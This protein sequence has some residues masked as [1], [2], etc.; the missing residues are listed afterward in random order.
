MKITTDLINRYLTNK[1]TAEEAEYLE[2]YIQYLGTSL[3]QLLPLEEWEETK[4]DLEYSGEEEIRAKILAAIVHKRKISFR[5]RMLV[6]LSGVAALLI[7]FLGIYLFLNRSEESF[8]ADRKDLATLTADSTE[9]S[10]L[11]YI[12]SG[13]ENMSLTASD[14]SVITLYPKSEIKYAENF[15]HLKERVLYLKGK[16]RFEVAKDK[17]KPFR[18]HSNGVTT[19][20]LGTIFIID[21]LRS[22][23]TNIKLLEGKIEVKAEDVKNSRKLIRTYEPN[24]EITLDHKDLKVLE[25]VKATGKGRDGYFVQNSE[26]IRFQNIALKDVLD[27]LEQNYNI[28]LQYDQDKIRDKYYSGV[29][30]NS[31]HVY[32]EIIKELNYLHHADINYTN[33]QH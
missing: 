6:K 27:L 20:A 18:V 4:G 9:V 30:V 10:N 3:D 15:R 19:T 28:K 12:N 33:L 14:G 25:E 11:Y 13:N 26:N 7:F 32:K 2:N 8:P 23:Q 17:S 24:E 16:A 21:E 1:C 31:R 5:R 29:Y 22:T